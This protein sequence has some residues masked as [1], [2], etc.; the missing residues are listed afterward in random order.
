MTVKELQKELAKEKY[1]T[2]NTPVFM[3]T[4]QIRVGIKSVE[5]YDDGVYLMPDT[6]ANGES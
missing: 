5:I 4:E 2:K 6:E 1:D 3:G